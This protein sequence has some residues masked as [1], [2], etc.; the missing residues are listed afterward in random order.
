MWYAKA[1]KNMSMDLLKPT[2]I[3]LV[4]RDIEF[5]LYTFCFGKE[6]NV[7]VESDG[8]FSETVDSW[9]SSLKLLFMSVLIPRYLKVFKT[10]LREFWQAFSF[11][12]LSFASPPP[13]FLV[14]PQGVTTPKNLY[15]LVPTSFRGDSL[16]YFPPRGKLL[17]FGLRGKSRARSARITEGAVFEIFLA[18]LEICVSGGIIMFPEKID[19]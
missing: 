19:N 12:W 9:Y 15:W 6:L 14:I 13:S 10:V 2:E 7:T 4:F 1:K 8:L 5:S 11:Y 18:I 3:T 16:S 17:D